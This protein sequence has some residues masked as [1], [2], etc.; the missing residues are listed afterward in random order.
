MSA[1][2]CQKCDSTEEC[3]LQ[4]IQISQDVVSG[5][6]EMHKISR[7]ILPQNPLDFNSSWSCAVHR[8]IEVQIIILMQLLLFFEAFYTEYVFADFLH[9][10]YFTD[11]RKEC[12]AN[13]A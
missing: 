8:Q 1:L 11:L 7:C 9:P 12:A 5:N 3:D 4:Q 13:S 6:S 2:R 10:P